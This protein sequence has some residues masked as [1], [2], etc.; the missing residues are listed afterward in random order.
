MYMNEIYYV[1]V[2]ITSDILISVNNFVNLHT[3]FLFTFTDIINRTITL[4]TGKFYNVKLLTGLYL[5]IPLLK[6]NF[7][8]LLQLFM[9]QFCVNT[10]LF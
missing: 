8:S 3:P 7:N 5:M 10:P 6:P 1:M 2:Y 9:L 4:Y